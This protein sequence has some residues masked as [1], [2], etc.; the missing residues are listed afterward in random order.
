[1]IKMHSSCGNPVG[2]C[3][4]RHSLPG[5]FCGR[6]GAGEARQGPPSRDSRGPGSRGQRR[7]PGQ[8]C[9]KP[10]D[11]LGGRGTM[12]SLLAWPPGTP[13]GRTPE[14]R[15]ERRDQGKLGGGARRAAC[16]ALPTSRAPAAPPS[17]SPAPAAGAQAGAQ[18]GAE[19]RPRSLGSAARGRLHA[20]PPAEILA[21]WAPPRGGSCRGQIAG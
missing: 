15:R 20:S 7:G 5:G 14:R 17:G 3:S 19:P 11:S 8:T 10:V 13:R 21:S 9:S 18:P 6:A 4:W 2:P 12:L 16:T 1:M